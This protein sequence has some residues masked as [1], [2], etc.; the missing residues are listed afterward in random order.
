M[1]LLRA[2][3]RWVFLLA[4]VLAGFA[5]AH[6]APRGGHWVYLGSS[7]VDGRADHDRINVSGGDGPFRALRFKVSGVSVQFDHVIVRYGNGQ[8][9]Q[10]AAN[11][12]VP[13]NSSSPPID[14]PG[15]YRNIQ[16]VEMWYQRGNWGKN[17]KVSVYG[18]R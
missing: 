13:G 10:L 9:Q 16:T 7:H 18:L 15:N 8:E 12:V 11:F 3:P 17:P 6:S 14:L 5:V 1:K 2:A 4:L